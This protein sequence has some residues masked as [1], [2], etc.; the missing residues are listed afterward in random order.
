MPSWSSASSH[1]LVAVTFVIS[2]VCEFVITK[3]F[4]AI[5]DGTTLYP[6]IAV[7]SLTLYMISFP[8][9][10]LG[11]PV[12]VTVKAPPVA[13]SDIVFSSSPSTAASSPLTTL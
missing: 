8:P 13:V 5:S 10:Y 1:A 11:R 9:S 2:G 4:L 7:S 3:L 6:S 12:H